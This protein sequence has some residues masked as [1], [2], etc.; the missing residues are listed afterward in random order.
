M[1]VSPIYGVNAQVYVHKKNHTLQSQD[2]YCNSYD[3]S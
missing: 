1:G 2:G 3:V